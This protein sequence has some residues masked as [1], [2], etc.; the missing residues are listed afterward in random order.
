LV[1]FCIAAAARN[2]ELRGA[3]VAV[4]PHWGGLCTSLL[5]SSCLGGRDA[6][7]FGR[8]IYW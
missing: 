5:S 8:I 3:P 1:E 4:T 6:L 2:W 7:M